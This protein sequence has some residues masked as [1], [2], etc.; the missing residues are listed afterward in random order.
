MFVHP[1][2]QRR[3]IGKGLVRRWLEECV[4]VDGWR[5][6]STSMQEEMLDFV[7][8]RQRRGVEQGQGGKSR[9][10]TSKQHGER[11]V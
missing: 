2:H 8:G 9:I 6:V 1:S 5:N 7:K 11:I 3:G 4:D 10:R